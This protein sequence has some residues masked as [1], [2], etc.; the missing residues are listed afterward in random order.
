MCCSG[1]RTRLPTTTPCFDHADRHLVSVCLKECLSLTSEPPRVCRRLQEDR[2]HEDSTKCMPRK[3]GSVRCGWCLSTRQSTNLSGPRSSRSPAREEKDGIS[4]NKK[5]KAAPMYDAASTFP[6][7]TIYRR[8]AAGEWNLLL[9]ITQL[10]QGDP[11]IYYGF[12]GLWRDQH[13]EYGLR[14]CRR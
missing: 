6:P 10:R 12:S 11:A 3:F 1:C 4:A 9:A 2:S 8:L 7:L 13:R 5:T 14:A